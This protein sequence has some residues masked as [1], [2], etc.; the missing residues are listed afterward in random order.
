MNKTYTQKEVDSSI[1]ILQKRQEV[2][3]EDRKHLNERIKSNKKQIEN[4]EELDLS[5]YKAF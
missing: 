3:L 1:N 4:W 5:Q 2:L